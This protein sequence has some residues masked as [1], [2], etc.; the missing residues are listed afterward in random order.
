MRLQRYAELVVRVGLNVQPGQ[1]VLSAPTSTTRPSRGR[2]SSRRTWRAR[3][4]SPSTTIDPHVRRSTLVHAPMET[5][6]TTPGWRLQQ[7]R[8]LRRRGGATVTLTGN[9]HPHLFDGLPAERVG[10]VPLD[11]ASASAGAG[12]RDGDVAWAVVAAP[13]AGWAEQVFGEPDLDRLWDAVAVAMRLDADDV[14][15]A[16]REHADRLHAR[17][18]AV[19]ALDLDSRALHR[20]GHRPDRRADPGLPVGQRLGDDQRGGIRSSPTCRPRRSSPRRTGG[21]PTARSA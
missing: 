15:A 7:L 16:W 17:G 8:Q 1:P 2:W 21:G 20:R 18:R 10:A 9:A 4:R 13:N 5:L 11:L 12:R 3:R 14:V 19:E 6:T